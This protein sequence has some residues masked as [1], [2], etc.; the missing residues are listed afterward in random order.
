VRP[1]R[2]AR[3]EELAHALDVPLVR[4]G[5][6]GGPRIVFDRIFETT[7]DEV[8]AAYQDALPDLLAP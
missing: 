3:L 7:V 1:E 6:T 8:R 5:E 2:A 4:I